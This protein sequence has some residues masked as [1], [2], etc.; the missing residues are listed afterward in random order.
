M[1]SSGWRRSALE[2]KKIKVTDKRMFTPDGELREEYRDSEGQPA[3]PAASSE[4]DRATDGATGKSGTEAPTGPPT[5]A[6]DR[7]AGA[8]SQDAQGFE[9]PDLG[10]D[11]KKPEFADLVAVLA[12]P[13]AMYLGDMPLPSGESAENLDAA[14]LY[15]DL[16]DVLLDK[17]RNNL[18]GSESKLLEELLYQTRLRYVQK[19][20]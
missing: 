18:S 3:A 17:T 19:C 11:A 14:R 9:M 6:A 8:G 16:L 1:E 15:I 12:Q 20:R 4:P 5:E 13:I 2:E 10:K 7:P